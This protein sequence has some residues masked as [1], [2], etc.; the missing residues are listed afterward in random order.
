MQNADNGEP[1]GIF[2]HHATC[3]ALICNS[4]SSFTVSKRGID[5]REGRPRPV[6]KEGK[7]ISKWAWLVLEL[8]YMLGALA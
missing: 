2:A 3:E 1:E 6:G 5:G 4:F 7:V 8:Y